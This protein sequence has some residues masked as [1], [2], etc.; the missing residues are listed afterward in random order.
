MFHKRFEI[1]GQTARA[2]RAIMLVALSFSVIVA[3]LFDCRKAFADEADF[4]PIERRF[5]SGS[6]WVLS[7]NTTTLDNLLNYPGSAI[8]PI[9]QV[10]VFFY[11]RDPHSQNW[12]KGK[13][14]EDLWF[15]SGKAI[16]CRRHINLPVQPGTYG[17]IYVAR[18]K[19]CASQTKALDGTVVRL[20]VEL[21]R[22][23]SVI[24]SVVWPAELCENASTDLGSFNFLQAAIISTGRILMLHFQSSPMGFDR[25]FTYTVNK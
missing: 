6:S 7:L 18:T 20:F 8:H 17:T 3:Q 22:S 13:L 25:Y 5:V 10:R 15:S 11:T 16:G 4:P 21:Y 2:H 1:Y 9:T 14:Y 12:G 19:D 24:T 23:N